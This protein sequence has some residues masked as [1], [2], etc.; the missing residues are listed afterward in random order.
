MRT[1]SVGVSGIPEGFESQAPVKA[2]GPS[3][4]RVRVADVVL[5]AAVGSALVGGMYFLM[6]EIVLHM[7]VYGL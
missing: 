3:S 7:P 1:Y 6:R 2:V 5:A 4:W